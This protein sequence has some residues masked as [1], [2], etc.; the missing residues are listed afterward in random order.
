[1]HDNGFLNRRRMMKQ[2]DVGQILQKKTYYSQRK[3]VLGGDAGNR[4]GEEL[5]PLCCYHHE[6]ILRLY[7]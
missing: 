4:K 5:G 1:L 7:S 6:L 2:H 3:Q